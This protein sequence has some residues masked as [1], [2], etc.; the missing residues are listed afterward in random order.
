MLAVY[1]NGAITKS[2]LAKDLC[3]L[4]L[5]FAGEL[6]MTDS[7]SRSDEKDEMLGTLTTYI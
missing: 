4:V 6:G 1:D 7:F 2:P 5:A 3:S